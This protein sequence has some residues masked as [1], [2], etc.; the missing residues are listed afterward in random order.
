MGDITQLLRRAR[1]GDE[2]ALDTLFAA[3]Q[4]LGLG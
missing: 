1:E 3:T 4:Q 2:A